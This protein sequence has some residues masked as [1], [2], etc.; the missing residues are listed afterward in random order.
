MNA[1]HLK[2]RVREIFKPLKLAAQKNT[3]AVRKSAFADKCVRACV[4]A[5]ALRRAAPRP[6]PGK[7][8][9]I[10]FLISIVFIIRLLTCGAHEVLVNRTPHTSVRRQL[11]RQHRV[12]LCRCLVLEVIVSELEPVK[13]QVERHV[14]CALVALGS[15]LR[16]RTPCPGRK[17]RT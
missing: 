11:Q 12:L 10:F 8:A 2:P 13:R 16:A 17:S 3:S 7:G 4:R 5:R 15:H 6:L 14:E 9:V 1:Q